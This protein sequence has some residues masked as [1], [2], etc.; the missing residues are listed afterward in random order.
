MNEALV[1][2]KKELQA[3]L[4]AGAAHFYRGEDAGG[5]YILM[6][7]MD[8]LE[9]LMKAAAYMEGAFKIDPKLTDAL[10]TLHEAAKNRDIAGLTDALA[11]AL[12]PQVENL[13][14][15]GGA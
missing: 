12:I 8:E 1:A 2:K 5:L 9:A 14:K 10:Q 6:R 13:W 4:A 3:M 15:E 11:Y 7:G